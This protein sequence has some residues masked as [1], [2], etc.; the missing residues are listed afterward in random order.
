MLNRV[1]VVLRRVVF[2]CG[3]VWCVALC[4]VELWLCCVMPWPCVWLFCSWVVLVLCC[5]VLCRRCVVLYCGA[6]SLM[7]FSYKAWC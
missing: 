3:V 1:V 5:A 4:C 6:L 7:M 2:R